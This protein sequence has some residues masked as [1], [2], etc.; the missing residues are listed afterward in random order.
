MPK[1]NG[2][3]AKRSDTFVIPSGAPLYGTYIVDYVS[4]ESFVDVRA[5]FNKEQFT[6][7]DTGIPHRI[8]NHWD[9]KGLLA[10]SVR[11]SEKN[12][13]KFSVVEVAWIRIVKHL[14]DF[15]VPLAK[16]ARAKNEIMRR[17]GDYYRKFEFYLF[18]ALFTNADPCVVVLADGTGGLSSPAEIELFRASQEH[19]DMLLI[20]LRRVLK[21]VGVTVP[22]ITVA[23]FV[24]EKAQA[25]T[26]SLYEQDNKEV[27]VKLQNNK[28]KE[29]ETTKVEPQN[30]QLHRITQQIKTSRIFG[31][32][33]TH[34]E[35][36]V[37]QSVE[38][39]ERRRFKK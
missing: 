2:A 29:I 14:R 20:P 26:R 17:D 3:K 18:I 34:F 15:G 7:A 39:K 21:E 19:A 13:R 27:R 31:E 4:S 24:D 23:S 32:V 35:C 36:G 9:E 33:T 28:I 10:N 1:E 11:D 30:P 6:V 5:M 37:P 22:E 8:V 12:W 38:I 25:L 16:I